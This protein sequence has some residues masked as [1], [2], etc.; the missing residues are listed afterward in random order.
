MSSNRWG[1]WSRGFL[2]ALAS[3]GLVCLAGHHLPAQREKDTRPPKTNVFVYPEKLT[4]KDK[5]VDGPSG[6]VIEIKSETTLIWVD[7]APDYRFAHPTEYV[8]IST[9]GARVVRGHW[10][11]VLNG[12]A[13]FRTGKPYQAEFPIKLTGK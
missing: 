9:A 4:E 3:I 5:L 7:L 6:R 11:P 8:L 2:V 13:L 1:T 12:K 10:W